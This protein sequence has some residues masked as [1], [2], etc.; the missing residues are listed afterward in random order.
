MELLNEFR[1][2]YGKE[3]VSMIYEYMEENNI[4]DEFDKIYNDPTKLFHFGVKYGIYEIVE[5]LYEA[6]NIEYNY[7]IILKY[8]PHLNSS[9][10]ILNSGKIPISTGSNNT[11]VNLQLWDRFS[12]YR[13][14]CINYLIKMAKYSR[15]RNE[16]GKFFY[17]FNKKNLIK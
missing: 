11:K 1:I 16:K 4:L 12:K 7:D 8:R 13:D 14:I 2:Q 10:Q 3:L 6:K 15:V 17:K 5:F 9:A